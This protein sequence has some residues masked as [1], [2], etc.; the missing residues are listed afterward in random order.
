MVFA[1]ETLNGYPTTYLTS[2]YI[3]KK[4]KNVLNTLVKKF[5]GITILEVDAML[6]QFKTIL[7]QLTTAINYLLYF[8][9]LAGFTVLFAAVY[10]TLDSRIYE[11]TLMRT[12]G[13]SR[14]LL[15]KAHLVEFALLGLI[16]GFVAVLMSEAI[17]FA[18]YTYVLHLDY[19]I[20]WILWMGIPL[21]STLCIM[22]TGFWG[23]RRVVKQS[24]MQV[25]REI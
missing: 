24:P 22:L 18:L 8:A 6:R 23:L 2:F 4:N 20:N 13:A 5:P 7:T 1:P 21:I 9:L 19:H 14:A 16:S 12:L 25:L 10:S 3:A 11:G 17:L 15:R